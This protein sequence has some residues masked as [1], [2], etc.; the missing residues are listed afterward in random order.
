MREIKFRAWDKRFKNMDFGSGDLL[1]RINS[2]DFSEPMQ[3]TGLKDK[4]GKEIYEG[5]VLGVPNPNIKY[6]VKFG[7]YDNEED[8]EDYQSGVGFYVENKTGRISSLTPQFG[9]EIIGN[10]YENKEL[11]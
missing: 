3:Y 5:D 7:S 11:L 1:L 9:Y 8:Y 6:V 10:L 4:N 2:K